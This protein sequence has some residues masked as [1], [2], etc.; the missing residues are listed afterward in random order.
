MYRL[1]RNGKLLKFLR[2]LIK[3]LS[4][5][6]YR[7]TATLTILVI[8]FSFLLNSKVFSI[9]VF[10]FIFLFRTNDME[11]HLNENDLS[12]CYGNFSKV[13]SW[14]LLDHSYAR[15]S[16][17]IIMRHIENSIVKDTLKLKI[18]RTWINMRVINSFIKTWEDIVKWKSKR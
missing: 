3:C 1:N 6:N 8:P 16:F 5:L 14:K 18:L 15:S 17:S 2:I 11:I 4:Q 10:I 12:H 7:A 9:R 13:P